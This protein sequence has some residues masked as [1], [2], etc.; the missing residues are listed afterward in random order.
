ME[1]CEKL[2]NIARLKDLVLLKGA[3]ISAVEFKRNSDEMGEW[4]VF[5]TASLDDTPSVLISIPFQQ[6]ISL[7]SIMNSKLRI[8]IDEN[9][10]LID[11]QDEL[12]A[13]ALMHALSSADKDCPWSLHVKT[14]PKT[15]N[16]TL[17]WSD[18]E[19]NEL[20]DISQSE[21]HNL[22]LNQ[23]FR[24]EGISE[25]KKREKRIIYQDINKGR[26]ICFIINIRE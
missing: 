6:C 19:L 18:E 14:L 23:S 12:L 15:F 25:K 22:E 16:T 21:L 9:P 5:T 17:F 3:S 13:I 26:I 24:K 8:I 10:G 4:G 20:F 1:I 11:Y 2:E 7:D